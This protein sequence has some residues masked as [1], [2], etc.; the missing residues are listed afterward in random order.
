VKLEDSHRA[1][2]AHYRRLLD[3]VTDERTR[4]VL[5]AMAREADE[6]AP[7]EELTSEQG[8][9][10]TSDPHSVTEAGQ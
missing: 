5:S 1:R 4:D 7:G 2:A 9:G 3:A 10:S 6:R 8:M